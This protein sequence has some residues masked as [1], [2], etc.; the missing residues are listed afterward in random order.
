MDLELHQ[1][2]RRYEQ[3]RRTSP[4]RERQLLASLAG[5][6]QRSPVVVVAAHDTFVLL[7]GYKRVRVLARLQVDT[8][9]ATVWDL[10]EDEGLLLERLMRTGE[11]ESPLEQGWLLRELRDRFGYSAEVLAARFDRSKSWVSRRLALVGELPAEVQE[12]VRQ[13][14]IGA[15]AAMRYLVPLA[16]AN[17]AECVSLAKAIA[18]LQAST[19]QVEV[20]CAAFAGGSVESR[21]MILSNPGLVL[22]AHEE[23]RR[24]DAPWKSPRELLLG[25]L[26]NLAC[27]ARRAERRLRE[28]ITAQLSV[29]ELGEIQLSFK[30]TKADIAQLFRHLSKEL[31][32]VGS[33]DSNHHPQTP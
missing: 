1:L 15:H 7:D 12:H 4:M 23:A 11:P 20:L 19:R 29:A 31:P 22:R 13:G 32:R 10:A 9:R 24:A 14:R 6:G 16:R 27:I 8:V 3:L 25:D 26:G 17:G 30:Q 33:A 18:P 28:G 21:T 2:D 5:G